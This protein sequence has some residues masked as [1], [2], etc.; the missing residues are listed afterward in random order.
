M[1]EFRRE[2]LDLEERASV[3]GQ[4]EKSE[5]IMKEYYSFVKGRGSGGGS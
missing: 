3:F 4:T 1:E 5:D 2:V